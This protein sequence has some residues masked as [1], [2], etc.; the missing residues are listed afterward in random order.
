MRNMPDDLSREMLPRAGGL[1][2]VRV[3]HCGV[4]DGARN[5][6]NGGLDVADGVH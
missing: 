6:D 5:E 3:V 2:L 1:P 4:V